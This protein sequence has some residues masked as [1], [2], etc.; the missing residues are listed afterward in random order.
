MLDRSTRSSS[1][2][3]VYTLIIRDRFS[4]VLSFLINSL[5][6]FFFVTKS[7]YVTRQKKLNNR[8]S[9]YIYLCK[10]SFNSIN[11]IQS[12]VLI[13]IVVYHKN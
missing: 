5:L 11:V 13:L 2:A 7:H 3:T 1:L 12:F 9:N 6:V 10:V 4:L 8:Q